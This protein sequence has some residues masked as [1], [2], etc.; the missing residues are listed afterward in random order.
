ML[1]CS[2]YDGLWEPLTT[3]RTVSLLFLDGSSLSAFARAAISITVTPSRLRRGCAKSGHPGFLRPRE[4]HDVHVIGFIHQVAVAPREE[5]LVDLHGAFSSEAY[6]YDFF[7]LW[8]TRGGD[9][10]VGHRVTAWKKGDKEG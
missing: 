2:G 4:V 6:E 10:D 7:V 9:G 5:S 3:G 1:V 8:S